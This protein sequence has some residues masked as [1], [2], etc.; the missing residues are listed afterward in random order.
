MLESET[1]PL[2]RVNVDWLLVRALGWAH[3][4]KDGSMKVLKH[5]LLFGYL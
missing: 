3:A 2:E 1:I 5:A 4:A